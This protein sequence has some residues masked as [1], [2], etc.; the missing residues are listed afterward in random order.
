MKILIFRKNKIFIAFVIIILIFIICNLFFKSTAK[1]KNSPIQSLNYICE[2]N[3]KIAYLTFDD[4]PTSKMTPKILDI[5]KS[6]DIKATFFVVGKQVANNPDIVKRAY[7]EGHFIANHGFSHNNKLLYKNSE[8]FIAEILNT[9]KEISKAIG[10]DDYHSH[11]FRFPNG[12]SAP[13]YKSRKEK[14]IT[15]L[16]AIHYFY[17]DW[18]CL[19]KDSEKK[20]SNFQLLQNLKNSTKNK[21]TL[22]ILMHDTGDVNNTNEV[23]KDSIDYLKSEGYQFKNFYELIS[24]THATFKN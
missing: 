15:K 18:N 20:Y 14:V 17:V 9:D 19:N 12:F 6:E 16:S 22:I 11:V 13:I 3:E 5:L 21:G 7:D 4:G 23:L 2:S 24:P 1:I 10:I 8:S